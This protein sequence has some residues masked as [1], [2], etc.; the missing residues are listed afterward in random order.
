MYDIIETE[1][2]RF[3]FYDKSPRTLHLILELSDFM[4]QICA[5]I[6]G[7]KASSGNRRHTRLGLLT[8]SLKSLGVQEIGADQAKKSLNSGYN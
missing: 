6:L 8:D 4:M 3:Y 5:D 2:S 1:V 7:V